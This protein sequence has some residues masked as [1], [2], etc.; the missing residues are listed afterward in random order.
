MNPEVRNNIY[1]FACEANE[2]PLEHLPSVPC[3]NKLSKGRQFYNLTQVCRQIRTEFLPIYA[4]MNAIRLPYPALD[5]YLKDFVRPLYKDN[6]SIGN[7]M[8]DVV[9]QGASYADRNDANDDE[10][11]YDEDEDE[12]EDVSDSGY[13]E[14]DI[15]P[16]INLCRNA[17]NLRIRFDKIACKYCG[18]AH[19]GSYFNETLNIFFELDKHPTLANYLDEAITGIKLQY[20]TRMTFQ[21]REDNWKE[22]MD[23]WKHRGGH[24]NRWDEMGAWCEELGLDV[25]TL[26]GASC[27]EQVDCDGGV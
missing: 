25:T 13:A 5:S 26:R 7:I 10:D 18:S 27:F 15:L 2:S 9:R 24:A 4:R 3:P 1:A 21:I 23:E 6:A 22:W 12:D 17:P 16:Y 20:P 19:H 14:I 11:D 8:V